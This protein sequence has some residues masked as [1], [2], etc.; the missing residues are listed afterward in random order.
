MSTQES[1]KSKTVVYF[2]KERLHTPLGKVQVVI[3]FNKEIKVAKCLWTVVE[4]DSITELSK[5]QVANIFYEMEKF[6]CNSMFVTWN[7]ENLKNTNWW[8]L[9]G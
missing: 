5:Y 6:C 3:N 1:L 4:A 8:I 9:H 7:L 2:R